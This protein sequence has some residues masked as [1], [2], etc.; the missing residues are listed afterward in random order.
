MQNPR[1]LSLGEVIH[2]NIAL[3]LKILSKKDPKEFYCASPSDAFVLSDSL[4]LSVINTISE[5]HF[6]LMALQNAC[7]AIYMEKA[8]QIGQFTVLSNE[9]LE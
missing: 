8:M 3:T 1:I 7:H 6:E 4:G 9:V 2:G 5:K